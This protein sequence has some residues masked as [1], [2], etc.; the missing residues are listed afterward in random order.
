MSGNV[1]IRAVLDIRLG[2][3]AAL[4]ATAWVTLLERKILGGAQ[5]RKGPNKVSWKGWLQP[6]ADAVKLFR[7]QQ[8]VPSAATVIFF[9]LAPV[10]GLAVTLA[11]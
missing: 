5:W 9:L 2:Y 11:A 7:K 8:P 4:L 10:F 3:V 1:A 6:I